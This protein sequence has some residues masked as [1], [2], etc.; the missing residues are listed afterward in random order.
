MDNFDFTIISDKT[1]SKPEWN[2]VV[3]ANIQVYT[4]GVVITLTVSGLKSLRCWN[5]LDGRFCKNRM[6]KIEYMMSFTENSPKEGINTEEMLSD[7]RLEFGDT[8]ANTVKDALST[9]NAE[10]HKIEN[11][12]FCA[13]YFFRLV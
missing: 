13:P 5:G 8:A 4:M 6:S 7:I 11:T 1:I 10:R 2:E 9:I 12:K 3:S